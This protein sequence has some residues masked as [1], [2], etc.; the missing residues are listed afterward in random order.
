MNHAVILCF[1]WYDVQVCSEG[2][3]DSAASTGTDLGVWV[4]CCQRKHYSVC[5]AFHHLQL[6]TGEYAYMY[7]WMQELCINIS[8]EK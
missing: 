8:S 7:T 6:I 1:I 4:V 3:S 2:V 5:L